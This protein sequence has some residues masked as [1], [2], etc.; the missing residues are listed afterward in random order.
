MPK[1]LLFVDDEVMLLDGLRRALRGMRNEWEMTFVGSGAEALQELDREHYDAVI[2]D[3]QMPHMDG[4]ELLEKVKKRHEGVVRIVLSGQSDKEAVLSSIDPTHQFLSK[5]CNLEELKLR[6]SLAFSMRDLF[7]NPPL[8]AIVARMR[9]IPS[10]PVLYN[11]LTKALEEQGTSL[12]ELE[13]IIEKDVAMATKVLQLAN[14]AFMGARGQVSSLLQAVS[15][16]ESNSVAA[17]YV[18]EL[19]SHS[20]EV[21]SLARQIACFEGQSRAVVEQCFSAGLLH[22]VGKA[23]LLAE[24]PVEYLQILGDPDFKAYTLVALETERFGCS[25]AQVG[26]YLMSIWGLPAPLVYA[27]AMHHQPLGDA[28]SQF[29]PLTAVYFADVFAAESDVAPLNRDIEMDMDYVKRLELCERVE[30][31][32]ELIRQRAILDADGG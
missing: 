24:M 21:A 6:L 4:A 5:P 11:E 13:H 23:I 15:L 20:V 17:L 7:D 29:S 9:A 3:M 19:W 10:L 22:D 30:A 27:V 26:A 14:S 25:H 28:K 31:W 12:T 32:R 8:K 2:T 18:A 16:M 1:R